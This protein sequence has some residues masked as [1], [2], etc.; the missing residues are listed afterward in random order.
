MVDVVFI[1]VREI[2]ASINKNNNIVHISYD[3]THK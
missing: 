1:L 2:E 3:T